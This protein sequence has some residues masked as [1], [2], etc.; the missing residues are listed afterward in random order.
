[1]AMR[2]IGMLLVALTLIFATQDARADSCK[3][4]VLVPIIILGQ[5]APGQQVWWE[6][7]PYGINFDASLPGQNEIRNG[8]VFNP[9]VIWFNKPVKQVILKIADNNVNFQSHILYAYDEFDR[10]VGYDVV[11]DGGS[12]GMPLVLN[13]RGWRSSNISKVVFE[14]R[15]EGETHLLQVQYCQR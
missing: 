6:F 11:E 12:F 3:N 2:I 9:Y 4:E 15:P 8:N 5:T 1:M 7:A 13:V 14:V 10:L